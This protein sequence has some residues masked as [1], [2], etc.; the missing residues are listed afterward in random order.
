MRKLQY[1]MQ[2]R[3]IAS[4]KNSKII[5]TTQ[6][7]RLYFLLSLWYSNEFYI[8]LKAISCRIEW[9]LFQVHRTKHAEVIMFILAFYHKATIVA[10]RRQRVNPQTLTTLL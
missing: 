7:Q 8:D 3:E 4:C 6:Y 5:L 2:K 10:L 9:S 1:V